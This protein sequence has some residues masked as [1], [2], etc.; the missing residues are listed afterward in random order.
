MGD[1]G[2]AFVIKETRQKRQDERVKTQ[3]PSERFAIPTS[4]RFTRLLLACL[5]K[6]QNG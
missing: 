5:Q 4:K 1:D 6:N 3:D 2:C